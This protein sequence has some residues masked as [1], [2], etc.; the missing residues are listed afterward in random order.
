MAVFIYF[1]NKFKIE[2]LK[3]LIYTVA[4]FFFSRFCRF[5]EY[6]EFLIIENRVR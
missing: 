1:L 5:L 2:F 3:T 6:P 4:N